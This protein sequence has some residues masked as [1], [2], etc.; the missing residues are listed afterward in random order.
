[1]FPNVL[2][3][4]QMTLNAMLII[5]FTCV[6]AGTDQKPKM[7]CNDSFKVG[8]TAKIPFRGLICIQLYVLFIFSL[9]SSQSP[10]LS[11]MKMPRQCICHLKPKNQSCRERK[12]K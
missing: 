1:M 6:Q 2:H 8:L 3:T 11:T 9:R 12:Q 7:K 4:N 10:L 5:S